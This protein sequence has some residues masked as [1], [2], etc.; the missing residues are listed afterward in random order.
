MEFLY[1]GKHELKLTDEGNFFVASL[2][3]ELEDQ[4]AGF[5][6]VSAKDIRVPSN[7]SFG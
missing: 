5:R 4:G 1:P 7:L 2:M 3:I 6:R